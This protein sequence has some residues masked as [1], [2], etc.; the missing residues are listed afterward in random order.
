MRLRSAVKGV[1]LGV[2][3]LAVLLRPAPVLAQENPILAYVKSRVKDPNKPFTLIVNLKVKEGAAK[4]L[5]AAFVKAARATRKEKG[6]RA[7]DLSRS[8]DDP[9]RYLVYE[10]WQS[11]A[12]LEEH[13]AT[14]HI[15]TLLGQ[16]PALL[17]GDPTP[18]VLIPAAE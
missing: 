13:L 2:G 17:A 10:R 11:V 1:C 4:N 9:T 14:P 12:A 7:Y 18:Q 3:L 16:L 6:C 8:T 15:K 5:E